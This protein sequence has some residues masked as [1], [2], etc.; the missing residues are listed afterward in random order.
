VW[1]GGLAKYQA[2]VLTLVE[3]RLD[4]SDAALERLRTEGY[5]R[6]FQGAESMSGRLRHAVKTFVNEAS[7]LNPKGSVPRAGD[8]QMRYWNQL[9]SSKQLL[10]DLMDKGANPAPWTEHC[11]RTAHA[12]LT[13][14]CAPSN[15]REY[16]ALVLAQ[17]LLNSK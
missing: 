6:A 17:S 9:D 16:R 3:S 4:L 12:V 5:L 8:A 11:F 13:E 15:A 10:F 1:A 7:R 2:N 14:I